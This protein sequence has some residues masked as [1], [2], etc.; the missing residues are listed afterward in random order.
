M[1]P[2]D[3]KTDDSKFETSTEKDR[4]A[5]L[6]NEVQF[7]KDQNKQ[8]MTENI[9][10]RTILKDYEEMKT[11]ENMLLEK[12]EAATLRE[13]AYEV[14]LEEINTQCIFMSQQLTK[15]HEEI[16]SLTKE[17][18]KIKVDNE[19]N[20]N[21]QETKIRLLKE[22]LNKRNEDIK[23]IEDANDDLIKLL[24]K[25]DEKLLK[26]DE[27]YKLERIKN[28]KFEQQLVLKASKLDLS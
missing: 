25:W 20:A 3:T 13:Q 23:Q 9:T 8:L 4:V 24:Q 21:H 18:K 17:N 7:L 10:L 14:K 28:E 15:C 11:N 6:E 2:R 12:L 1:S 27:D 16:Q 26:L 5:E 22:A 19:M